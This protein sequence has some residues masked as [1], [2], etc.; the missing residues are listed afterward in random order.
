[1][2]RTQAIAPWRAQPKLDPEQ[3]E[4]FEKKIRPLLA[5]NCYKCHSVEAGKAK[6]GLMLDTREG[7]PRAARHGRLIVPGD[8]DKSLLIRRSAT[9]TPTCRCRRRARS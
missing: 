2:R 4:F 9:R 6:G 8:P 5:E 7:W 3:V 1:M